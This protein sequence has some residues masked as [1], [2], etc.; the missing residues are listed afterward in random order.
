VKKGRAT[1][2]FLELFEH[3]DLRRPEHDHMT[4]Q[5]H[6]SV[7]REVVQVWAEHGFDGMAHED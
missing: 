4:H 6:P 3:S 5:A 1:L 2:D 7:T